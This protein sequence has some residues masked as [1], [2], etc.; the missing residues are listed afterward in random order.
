MEAI[1]TK[2]AEVEADLRAVRADMERIEEVLKLRKDQQLMLLGAYNALTAI[3]T[4]RAES[5][6]R[7][8]DNEKAEAFDGVSGKDEGNDEHVGI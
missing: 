7:T 5:D 4:E 1:E 6:L 2:R 8:S 3:L